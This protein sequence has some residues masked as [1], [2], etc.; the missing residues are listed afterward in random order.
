MNLDEI[1]AKAERAGFIV[2]QQDVGNGTIFLNVDAVVYDKTIDIVNDC[3]PIASLLG[4]KLNMYEVFSKHEE[5]RKVDKVTPIRT[6]DVVE[7]LTDMF[8]YAKGKVEVA[9]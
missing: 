6:A 3:M 4:N 7:V 9:E 2:K 1:A 8:E 5:Y